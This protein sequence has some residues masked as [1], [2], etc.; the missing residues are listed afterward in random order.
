[1]NSFNALGFLVLGSLMNALP[2]LVPSVVAR[3]PLLGDMTPSAIWLH[4][5]GL[6]VGVIGSSWL[7]REGLGA[8]SASRRLPMPA[9]R[10][11]V[12]VAQPKVTP[13]VRG[14]AQAA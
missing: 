12:P 10:R 2:V 7:V 13:Q 8:Y 14:S 11:L 6:V 5:M 3:G 9:A 4:F 1:M